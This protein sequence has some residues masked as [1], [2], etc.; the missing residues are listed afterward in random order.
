MLARGNT[1][2]QY[3]EIIALWKAGIKQEDLKTVLDYILAR[4]NTLD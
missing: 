4:G 1:A 2:D 3:K